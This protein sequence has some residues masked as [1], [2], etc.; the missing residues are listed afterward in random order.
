[1]PFVSCPDGHFY[2][3]AKSKECPFCKSREPDPLPSHL[4]VGWLVATSGP[5]CGKDFTLRPGT[6]S[7]G[8]LPSMAVAIDGDPDVTAEDHAIVAYEVR[9]NRFLLRPGP[10]RAVAYRNGEVVLSPVP[11]QVGDKV[12]VGQTT[13]IFIPLAGDQF[14]W[15]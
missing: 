14:R 1:M 15:T 2:D 11:L 4:P 10:G 7:I 13:L 3:S 12:T 9:N 8:S 6:N 5:G